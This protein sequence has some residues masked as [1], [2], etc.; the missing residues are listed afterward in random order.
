MLKI[1]K[2]HHMDCMD[3]L[4]KL[5]NNSIDLIIADPPYNMNKADWDSFENH[6]SFL[7]FSYQWLDKAIAKLKPSGSLYVFNTPFNS[8]FLCQYLVSQGMIFQNWITW[9]KRDGMGAAKRRYSTGQETIL[10]FTKSKNHTFNFND[11]RVPYESTERIN[12]AK[13]KGILKNGK[14]W[15][16]NANGRLCG[17]VWHFSSQRHKAKVNGKVVK[18]NHITPK[19]HDLIERII[20]ASSNPNDLIMDCFMGSGTTAIVAKKLGRNFIGCEKN[21]EYVDFANNLYQYI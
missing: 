19:P 20:K 1:N 16:P 14:R 15:F 6:E 18:L 5:D 17:E 7:N 10:F 11:I 21:K 3:F 12:H 4:E 2:I 9:D 8:A 13:E